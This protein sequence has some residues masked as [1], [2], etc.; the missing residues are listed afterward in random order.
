[1]KLCSLSLVLKTRLVRAVSE[2]RKETGSSGSLKHEYSAGRAE[3]AGTIYQPSRCMA[4]LTP[5]GRG[6]VRVGVWLLLDDDGL[7][8]N[9][10]AGST[11]LS[12]A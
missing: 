3:A 9:C 10:G 1:M 12:I 6:G 7:E 5:A 4:L 11:G 2:A 8:C